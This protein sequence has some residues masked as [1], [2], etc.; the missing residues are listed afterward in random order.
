MVKMCIGLHVKYPSILM[1]LEFFSTHFRKK[2]KVSDFMKILPKGA[3]L[4]HADGQT[5]MTTL[6]VAFR[7]FTNAPK[8]E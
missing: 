7:K 4:C 8:S 6:M 1:T 3:E 5:D 2:K